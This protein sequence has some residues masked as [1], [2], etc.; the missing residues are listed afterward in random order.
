MRPLLATLFPCLLGIVPACGPL[1]VSGVEEVGGVADPGD[2]GA[3]SP[4][5]AYDTASCPAQAAVGWSEASHTKL[6]TADYDRVLP[7]DGVQRLDIVICDEWFAA[8]QDNLAAFV[9]AADTDAE[10]GEAPDAG[11]EL[12]EP[13]YVEAAVSYGGMTWPYVGVRYKG[14]SSLTYSAQAGI[15]KLPLRLDFD[16]WEDARPETDDQRFF[17]FKVLSLSPGYHDPAYTREKLV[18]EMLELEGVPAVRSAFYEVWIDAG[19]GPTY[20]GLYTAIEDP[21][22]KAFLDR[23]FGE[24][25]GNLYQ[26]ESGCADWECFDAEDFA[27]ENHQDEADWSDVEAAIAALHADRTDAAAWR[28]GL[29]AAF[30]VPGFMRWLAVNTSMGNWDSYGLMP[31]NYFL[32]GDPGH[33]GRLA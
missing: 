24:N 11:A 21:S 2:S 23:V 19:Q 33:G 9:A 30:D 16:E 8:M 26:P 22:N 29:E 32:Y 4:A 14:N 25:A 1:A 31:H 18:D 27:K 5:P 15:Q 6:G 17:G 20:W 10:D 12:D 3:D 13:I 28:A 7:R